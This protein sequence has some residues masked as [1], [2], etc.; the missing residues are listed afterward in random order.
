MVS[1]LTK[2][3]LGSLGRLIG[4]VGIHDLSSETVLHARFEIEKALEYYQV[5][6]PYTYSNDLKQRIVAAVQQRQQEELQKTSQEQTSSSSATPA[7]TTSEDQVDEQTTSLPVNFS[8]QDDLQTMTSKLTIEQLETLSRLIGFVD[9]NDQFVTESSLRSK[10]QRALEYYNVSGPYIYSNDLKQRIVAVV[11]KQQQEIL[12][13][14]DQIAQR[15]RQ[16]TI[17][18]ALQGEQ[19][20]PAQEK[21][22]E[23]EKELPKQKKDPIKIRYSL[24]GSNLSPQFIKQQLKRLG[25]DGDDADLIYNEPHDLLT[26]ELDKY[27][28][29]YSQPSSEA[30]IREFLNQWFTEEP[31]QSK[32]LSF[33]EPHSSEALENIRQRKKKPIQA[34][35]QKI[36]DQATQIPTNFALPLYDQDE[37]GDKSMQFETLKEDVNKQNR[38][39]QFQM[40][41]DEKYKKIKEQHNN[42]EELQIQAFRLLDEEMRE[43]IEV[44]EGSDLEQVEPIVNVDALLLCKPIDSDKFI[45]ALLQAHAQYQD[46]TRIEQRRIKDEP[47]IFYYNNRITSLEDI[48]NHLNFVFDKEK[49][50]HFKIA[51][52]FGYIVEEAITNNDGSNK[53]AEYTINYPRQ[54]L[55]TTS[56]KN[57]KKIITSQADMDE[58]KEYVPTIIVNDQERTQESTH[59][60]FIAIF[61]MVVVVYRYPLTGKAIPELQKYI[62]RREV[63]FIDSQYPNNCVFEALSFLSLPDKSKEKRYKSSDRV[64]EGVKLM[65]QYYSLQGSSAKCKNIQKFI[66]EYQGFDFVTDGKKLAKL[67]NI[68]ICIY[69]CKEIPIQSDQGDTITAYDQFYLDQIIEPDKDDADDDEKEY[70]N[71]ENKSQLQDFNI[72]LLQLKN[73]SHVLFVSDPEALT[74]YRN[75]PF[76]KQH[77]VPVKNKNRNAQRDFERH[78]AKCQQNK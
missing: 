39:E 46:P 55:N 17:L 76:C 12:K 37:Q 52:D 4:F 72:I 23:K 42:I 2:E 20:L 5:A 69:A 50:N 25:Y 26:F 57:I 19:V 27:D 70:Q 29:D 33:L 14:Q 35:V 8:Q 43:Q 58:F 61:S 63:H 74:G 13:L 18:P 66:K 22:K 38:R 64:A 56:A 9:K 48:Q 47:T 54:N 24:D 11:Q 77:S 10:L 75:C 3:Q 71:E 67:F 59:H 44:N 36:D 60:K 15:R 68:N 53:T 34:P 62:K 78:V 28:Y 65:I 73:N 7:T 1:R 31:Q 45:I 32:D 49:T 41:L 6:R 40:Y 30:R 21:E 51:I 16:A